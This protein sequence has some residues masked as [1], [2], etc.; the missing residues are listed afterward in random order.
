[1]SLPRAIVR[2]LPFDQLHHLTINVKADCAIHFIGIAGKSILGLARGCLF[3]KATKNSHRH[4]Y[5]CSSSPIRRFPS[6][7]HAAAL[8]RHG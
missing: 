8:L 5:V 4:T 2:P 6:I 1:M 7:A 3:P